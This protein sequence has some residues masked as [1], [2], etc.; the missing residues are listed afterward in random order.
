MFIAIIQSVKMQYRDITWERDIASLER[1]SIYFS[2]IESQFPISMTSLKEPTTMAFERLDQGFLTYMAME[3][4][5]Y[6]EPFA[7]GKTII[8][9]LLGAF[10]PR[11]LWRDKPM[12]GGRE[13]MLKYAGKELIGATSMNI[14]QFGEAYVNFG[15]LGGALFLFVWA[16]VL[17]YFFSWFDK[18]FYVNPAILI[19][20]PLFWVRG[21]NGI[22]TDF[23]TVFNTIIKTGFILYFISYYLRR[24]K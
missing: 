23:G 2:L 9:S 6:Q 22:G 3:Y 13:M 21:L 16:I 19:W 24:F 11:F 18:K 5:P 10:V 17:N 4:V 1:F 15:I 8:N 12:A 7:Y 14:G 20:L